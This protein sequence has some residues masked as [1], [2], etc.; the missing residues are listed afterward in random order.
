MPVLKIPVSELLEC[1]VIGRSGHVVIEQKVVE[2]FITEKILAS[3]SF[4]ISVEIQNIKS[5]I[6]TL[7]RLTKMLRKEANKK[8]C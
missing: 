6:V 4:S 1:L 8:S 2:K 3:Q 7:R 5:I